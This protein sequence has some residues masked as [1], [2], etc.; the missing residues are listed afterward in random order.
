MSFDEGWMLLDF[1]LYNRG[2]A[3]AVPAPW[4]RTSY[5]LNSL[6]SCVRR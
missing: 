5:T 6:N 4:T 3:A 1:F 2:L